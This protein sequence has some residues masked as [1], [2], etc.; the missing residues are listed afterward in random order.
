MNE[1]NE[2]KVELPPAPGGMKWEYRGM[3]WNPGKAVPAYL[4]IWA[5]AMAEPAHRRNAVPDGIDD[6]HYWEAVPAPKTAKQ[7]LETYLTESRERFDHACD[8]HL[9]EENRKLNKRLEVAEQGLSDLKEDWSSR[10]KQAK[11]LDRENE[12]LKAELAAYPPLE[13]EWPEKPAPPEGC[14]WMRMP[15]EGSFESSS[16]YV[17]MSLS[18]DEWFENCPT[19]IG[20]NGRLVFRAEKIDHTEGGKYRMLAEG[21]IVE[22]GDA[23]LEETEWVEARYCIGQPLVMEP[24]QFWRRP[25]AITTPVENP[26]I[27]GDFAQQ[28]KDT[29]QKRLFPESR[30]GMIRDT[31]LD[32]FVDL[33]IKAAKQP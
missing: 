19:D 1:L 15:D 7:W 33:I 6:H 8:D 11:N 9:A 18:Y 23:F 30:N 31:E 4:T 22:Q 26:E 24:G 28:A 20:W 5:E 13:S 10:V 12:S 21:E 3:G 27:H 25:A 2:P 16:D 14:E 32:K 29:L 17:Y